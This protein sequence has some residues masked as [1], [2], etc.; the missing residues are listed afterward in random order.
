[1]FT[2]AHLAILTAV[3]A[4]P[5]NKQVRG[6]AST[7]SHHQILLHLLFLLQGKASKHVIGAHHDGHKDEGVDE[8][9]DISCNSSDEKQ[10]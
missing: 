6:K 2:S 7:I 4:T 8:K 10:F 3:A 9:C 5:A 1:M